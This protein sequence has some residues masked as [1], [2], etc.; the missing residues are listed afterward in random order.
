VLQRRI[1]NLMAEAI[2]SGKLVKGDTA[3]I[4]FDRE[5]FRLTKRAG[6]RKMETSAN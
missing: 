2:L 1:Q 4:D 6:E 3:L 5:T